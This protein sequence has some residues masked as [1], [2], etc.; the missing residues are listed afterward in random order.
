MQK[1]E[2]KNQKVGRK[3]QGGRQARESSKVKRKEPA[4][5]RYKVR[6]GIQLKKSQN[7]ISQDAQRWDEE[8]LNMWGMWASAHYRQ[9]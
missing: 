2:E 6:K 4:T 5:K 1:R 9:F 8:S 7:Y 3:S